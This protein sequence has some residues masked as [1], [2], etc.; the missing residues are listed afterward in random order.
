MT[1][2]NASYPNPQQYPSPQ[3][4]GPLSPDDDKLW[5]SLC[6]FGNI[7]S[8]LAPLIIWLVLKDRGVRVLH[9]GRE[10]V[11]W[12]I[13]VAGFMFACVVLTAFVGWIPI[14]GWIVSGLLWLAMFAVGVL[15]LVFAIIGGV[16]V[17]NG[18]AYLYPV[19]IRW[20]K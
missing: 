19:N 3:P 16:K 12:G 18:G 20:I 17:S 1:D 5:A 14:F 2:P 6:H 4:A 9:E 13:N 11:N 7:L 10:A 8:V 15:N